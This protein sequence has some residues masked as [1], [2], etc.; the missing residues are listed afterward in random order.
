MLNA[1]YVAD[2]R[3]CLDVVEDSESQNRSKPN[4][5]DKQQLHIYITHQTCSRVHNQ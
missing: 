4:I 5:R 1:K 2:D 3:D